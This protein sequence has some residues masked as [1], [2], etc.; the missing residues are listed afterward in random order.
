MV[1]SERRDL[2]YLIKE[3]ENGDWSRKEDA[4]ELLAELADPRAVDPL[5]KALKDEDFHV[6][7]AAALSLA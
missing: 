3:L 7:E 1:E 4:A 6:R 2:D 5:I